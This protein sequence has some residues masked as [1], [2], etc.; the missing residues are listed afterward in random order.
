MATDP[1]IDRSGFIQASTLPVC[2]DLSSEETVQ[3]IFDNFHRCR[4]KKCV[5]VLSRPESITARTKREATC[6]S[7]NRKFDSAYSITAKCTTTTKKLKKL[8]GYYTT[9]EM[10]SSGL[11]MHNVYTGKAYMRSPEYCEHET[12]ARG[13]KTTARGAKSDMFCAVE[14]MVLKVVGRYSGRGVTL[15][16][17]FEKFQRD[18]CDGFGRDGDPHNINYSQDRN[19]DNS[20]GYFLNVIC[21]PKPVMSA[22]S[23][24]EDL[25]LLDLPVPALFGMLNGL[26]NAF[27]KAESGSVKEAQKQRLTQFITNYYSRFESYFRRL[28]EKANADYRSTWDKAWKVV[29]EERSAESA[30]EA[31]WNGYD[32]YSAHSL[33]LV[34]HN[35]YEP[36]IRGEYNDVS[37]SESSL[38]IG[39]VVGAS[40]VIIIVLIFCLGLAFGM[41]IYWGYSQKRA[42]ER[43]REKGEMRNWIDDDEDRNEV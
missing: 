36:L 1:E 32:A 24:G 28:G 43:K 34:D 16:A 22:P 4:V 39:G 40:S 20:F 6:S 18:A 11:S 10:S 7:T 38:L 13:A 25:K 23:A 30:R 8:E 12:T 19:P 41:V 42:L 21:K 26:Y 37:G 33:P 9:C 3:K 14:E 29:R 5:P 17:T 35:H 15:K 27:E 2:S 31:I